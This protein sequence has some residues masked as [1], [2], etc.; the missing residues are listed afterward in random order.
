[1]KKKDEENKT[2]NLLPCPPSGSSRCIKDT[3]NAITE[4]IKISQGP[5]YLMHKNIYRKRRKKVKHWTP[6][7]EDPIEFPEIKWRSNS[8]TPVPSQNPMS[9]NERVAQKKRK[10][11]YLSPSI[12]LPLREKPGSGSPRE[13]G[14]VK[15]L[16]QGYGRVESDKRWTVYDH[17]SELQ[18]Q[19]SIMS[20]EEDEYDASYIN[21]HQELMS[22]VYNTNNTNNTNNANN[23]NNA[24]TTPSQHS[25]GVISTPLSHPAHNTTQLPNLN[26][27]E[28][29]NTLPQT[30]NTIKSPYEER[31]SRKVI[32]YYTF[33]MLKQK[34]L[35]TEEKLNKRPLI[36]EKNI[37][38][39]SK[40]EIDL[41]KKHL[42]EKV[43]QED[44]S[45][46]AHN[47]GSNFLRLFKL[48][49]Y[50]VGEVV[51]EE[52]IDIHEHPRPPKV[53]DLRTNKKLWRSLSPSNI[54]PI[55]YEREKGEKVEQKNRRIGNKVKLKHKGKDILKQRKGNPPHLPKSRAPIQT[56]HISHIPQYN[57]FNLKPLDVKLPKVTKTHS[58]IPNQN[59]GKDFLSNS[60]FEHQNR[61]HKMKNMASEMKSPSYMNA[62]FAHDIENI[63]SEK[64]KI[65]RFR[66]LM[67]FIYINI[68]LYNVELL[69]G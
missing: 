65:K 50:K 64:E 14:E 61:N 47:L 57:Q 51:H 7:T 68:Y 44:L 9:K 54:S 25:Q 48:K 29:I 30:S 2:F 12:K 6:N 46:I 18:V 39:Y 55:N 11:A 41:G 27:Q 60:I 22:P 28:V 10:F 24:N 38:N 66:R 4:F 31:E 45:W 62:T 42:M 36:V 19:K 8:G 43:K 1:M 59:K 13:K 67:V 34:D 35:L 21:M 23:A 49:K 52:G 53:N 5:K 16:V 17:I 26:T 15:L 20:G 40:K 58:L 63:K 32:K 56:S 33:S 69:H 37:G 3:L